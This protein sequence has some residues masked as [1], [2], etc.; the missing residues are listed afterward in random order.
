MG[1]A[2][3][4]FTGDIFDL[5]KSKK[6]Q[7][8]MER[9]MQQQIDRQNKELEKKKKDA[10]DKTL[11]FYESFRGGNLSMLKPSTEQVIG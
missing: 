2:V 11:G 6:K 3:D 4:A 8:E 5:D 7:R 10:K 1:S 9:Q